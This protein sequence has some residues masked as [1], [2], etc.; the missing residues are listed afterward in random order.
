[1]YL[2]KI[3]KIL[4]CVQ[5]VKLLF[6][7]LNLSL[8]I[9]FTGRYA[10]S[11]SYFLSPKTVFKSFFFP[12]QQRPGYSKEWQHDIYNVLLTDVCEGLSTVWPLFVDIRVLNQT[13]L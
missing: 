8:I 5:Q 7:Y 9:R 1:M 12:D 4:A 10:M 11:I 3:L 13:Q 2:N 6:E